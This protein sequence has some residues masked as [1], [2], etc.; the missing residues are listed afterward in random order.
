M[1]LATARSRLR[2]DN[3]EGAK[4]LFETARAIYTRIGENLGEADALQW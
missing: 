1:S 3:L 2:R 4:T